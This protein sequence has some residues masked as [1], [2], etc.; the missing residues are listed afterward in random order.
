VIYKESLID[1]IRTVVES[2]DFT[3]TINSV[4]GSNPYVLTVCDYYHAEPGRTV[5]IGGETFTIV[6]LGDGTIT[7][8]TTATLAGDF[9]TTNTSFDLYGVHFFHGTPIATGVLERSSDLR[10]FFLTQSEHAKTSTDQADIRAIAP[11]RRLF[12]HFIIK[13]KAY[14]NA[15]GERV[16]KTESDDRWKYR[17]KTKEYTQFGV[18][19]NEKGTLQSKWADQLSGLEWSVNQPLFKVY[20]CRVC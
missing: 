14:R 1:I 2:L 17:Y 12:E 15:S 18:Y 8:S 13:I 11:M 6:S 3:V 7:V 10:L 19:I 4:T 9:W 16:F 20:S 5:T